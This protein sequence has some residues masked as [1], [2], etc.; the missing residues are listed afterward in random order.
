MT[1]AVLACAV[2][3]ALAVF[4]GLLVAGAPTSSSASL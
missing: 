1:A 4:Q 3:A 2:L